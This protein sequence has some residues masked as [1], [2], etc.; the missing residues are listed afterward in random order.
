MAVKGLKSRDA[1][2][3]LIGVDY[4]SLS[5]TS[6]ATPHVS[7]VAALVWSARPSLTAEQVRGLLQD[8]AKDLGAQGR[9]NIYGFG[10]VQAKKAVDLLQTRYP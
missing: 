1:K 2:L 6:M 9:D 5:G 7:G 10:L 8:S 4:A 3:K